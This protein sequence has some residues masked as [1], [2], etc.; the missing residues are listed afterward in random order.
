MKIIRDVC[1]KTADELLMN[2]PLWRRLAAIL[3]DSLLLLALWFAA[4]LPYALLLHG[5]PASNLMRWL[6][7]FYLLAV[8]L[9][10]FGGFWVR[11]GQTLGMRAWRL[12]VVRQDGAPI[13][14]RQA[15][16]RWAYA[17]ISWLVLGLGFAW[18]AFDRERLTWHD[19]WSHTRL[20][21]APRAALG[22]APKQV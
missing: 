16:Q 6:F 18:A 21:V 13:R 14:W 12:R 3:Y 9:A 1:T 8:S 20:V 10:F 15:G 4:A 22:D 11:G 7:R 2:A 5:A 19:R 17:L